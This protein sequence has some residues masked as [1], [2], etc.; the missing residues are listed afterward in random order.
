MPNPKSCKTCKFSKLR[1]NGKICKNLSKN[2]I[3]I[4][5]KEGAQ[6]NSIIESEHAKSEPPM[7]PMYTTSTKADEQQ[8]QHNLQNSTRNFSAS[9][10][11]VNRKLK[12][13]NK[14]SKTKTV[15]KQK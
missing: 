13:R 14:N 3:K 6:T 10:N 11:A 4:T 1:R 8:Q 5:T 7:Y 2:L 12:D 9:E 15:T